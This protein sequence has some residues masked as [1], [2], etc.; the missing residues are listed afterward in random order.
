MMRFRTTNEYSIGYRI[1]RYLRA[2][3]SELNDR[4]LIYLDDRTRFQG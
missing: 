3:R 2:R 4:L 1:R